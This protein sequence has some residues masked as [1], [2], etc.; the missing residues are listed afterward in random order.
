VFYWPL[1]C[2][3]TICFWLSICAADNEKTL[4]MYVLFLSLILFWFRFIHNNR[5]DKR[6]EVS[7]G[8]GITIEI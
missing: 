8:I 5:N 2:V 3:N 7:F 4:L 1:F 6:N